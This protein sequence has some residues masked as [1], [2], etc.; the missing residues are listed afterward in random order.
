MNL[1][2]RDE[3]P[4]I[5]HLRVVVLRAAALIAVIHLRRVAITCDISFR[6]GDRSDPHLRHRATFLEITLFVRSIAQ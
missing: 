6:G 4:L 3:L 2:H 1:G 5:L